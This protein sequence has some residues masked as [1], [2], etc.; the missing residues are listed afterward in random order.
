M[1][2]HFTVEQAEELI[3]RLSVLMG[4][5][6]VLKK[7]I[8]AKVAAWRRRVNHG[9]AAQAL[10]QGQVD[11]MVGQINARL[12]EL[13]KTGCQPKDL[14]AGLVDFPARLNGREISL[15]WKYGEKH[16]GFWHGLEEGFSGRK[17]LGSNAPSRRSS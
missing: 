1:S 5:V 17:P 9:T 16:I 11:F 3:P 2:R 14:D 12:E 15:C 10:V 6:R 4:E 13:V 7:R 8:D